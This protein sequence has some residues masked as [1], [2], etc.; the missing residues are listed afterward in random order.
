MK[1][2]VS[3]TAVA[4]EGN[5]SNFAGEAL[6][7]KLFHESEAEDEY[8]EVYTNIDLNGERAG[9]REKDPDYRRPLLAA[10][11]QSDG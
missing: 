2:Q 6:R 3:F 4:L 1:E 7:M 10:I 11:A 5:P 9:I 8:A